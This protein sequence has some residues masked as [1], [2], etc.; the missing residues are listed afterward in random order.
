MPNIIRKGDRT[1][2]GGVVLEGFEHTNFNGR[3]LAGVGHKVSCP[4]CNGVHVIA[5][6]IATYKVGGIP[7]AV[8]GMKTTCGASLIASASTGKI[9]C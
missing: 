4:R 7:V 8:E 9:S 1:D 3:P 6:G 2:H 5:E